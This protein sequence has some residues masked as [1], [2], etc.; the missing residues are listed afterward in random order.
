[1]RLLALGLQPHLILAD[2]PTGNLDQKTG[3]EIMALLHHLHAAGHTIVLVTH[4][5]HVA[6]QAERIVTI[7]DGA[8]LSD[9]KNQIDPPSGE[10]P[11]HLLNSDVDGQK[12]RSGTGIRWPDQLRQALREGILRTAYA[13]LSPCWEL[14]LASRQSSR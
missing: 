4:D 14:C 12:L 3:R 6:E 13:V 10:A 8:I 9:E 7:T 11:V 1:M 5:R 2:E